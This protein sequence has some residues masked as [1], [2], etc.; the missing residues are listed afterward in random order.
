MSNGSSLGNLPGFFWD[1]VRRRYFPISQVNPSPS[2]SSR[3]QNANKRSR[4]PESSSTS[5]LVSRGKNKKKENNS[6][7]KTNDRNGSNRDVVAEQTPED[8]DISDATTSLRSMPGTRW[9]NARREIRDRLSY[10]DREK[11][12]HDLNTLGIISRL[13]SGPSQAPSPSVIGNSVTTFASSQKYHTGTFDK[14][15]ARPIRFIGDSQGWLYSYI[16]P[17]QNLWSTSLA[18]AV[19]VLSEINLH[20]HGE[21]YACSYGFHTNPTLMV[22]HTGAPTVRLVLV[23]PREYL[24][25]LYMNQAERQLLPYLQSMTF[26]A[27]QSSHPP[28]TF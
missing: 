14:W 2:T 15:G 12:S 22:A 24:Y 19:E 17:P 3:G 10:A 4:V 1:P 13:S 9:R 8:M 16:D 5:Q 11:A 27:L 20:P 18:D 25:N 28:P 7:R 21:I 23:Q 26:D 6:D